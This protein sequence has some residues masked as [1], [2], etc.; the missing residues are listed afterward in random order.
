M[1]KQV[2]TLLIASIIS[3]GCAHTTPNPV[4][5][6]QPGDEAKTCDGIANEMQQ[7]IQAQS[8]AEADRNKQVA[9]NVALGV[10]GVFLIVP[11]FFMDTGNAATVEERAAQAR[12][13]R[14]MQMQIDKKCPATPFQTTA[15]GTP[16]T[17]ATAAAPAAANSSAQ[18]VSAVAAKP[19]APPSDSKYM[20][21]AEQFAKSRSCATPVAT[22]NIRTPVAETFTITCSNSDPM[23]I[24]CEN[25]ACR[26][27]E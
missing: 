25:G 22:M 26:L 10:A 19:S 23:S 2:A 27:L 1:K 20:Y 16:T 4:M 7:M 14:L 24:R 17:P 12:F 21:S 9:G 5:L 18:A 8:A 3:S 13:Q 6:A 15:T 11:W